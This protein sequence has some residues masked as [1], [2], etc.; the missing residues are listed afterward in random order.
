MAPN[1][2]QTGE[3]SLQ[4]AAGNFSKTFFRNCCRTDQGTEI[5]DDESAVTTLSTYYLCSVFM[6]PQ[7]LHRGGCPFKIRLGQLEASW[8]MITKHFRNASTVIEV[9]I[10]GGL[11]PAK[12]KF[13]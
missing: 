3:D 2:T 10:G 4:L 1:R 11:W 12:S 7:D 13:R 9:F 5:P 6:Q 8:Y